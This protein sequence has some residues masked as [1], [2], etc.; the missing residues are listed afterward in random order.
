[1]TVR[2]EVSIAGVAWPV[3]KLLALA[4]G[5]LVLVIVALATS[6]AAPSVL[7]AATAGTA[8]WLALSP[9]QSTGR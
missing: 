1:M 5:L 2:D 3:Y 9:F 4:I 6:S 7:A 8:V